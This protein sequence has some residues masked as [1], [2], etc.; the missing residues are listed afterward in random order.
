MKK[1]A[2]FVE[3]QTEQF[4]IKKLLIE[5]AG[6]KNINVQLKTF[7]GKGKSSQNVFPRTDIAE[8]VKHTALVYNCGGDESVKSRILEEYQDL[9]D[10][11]YMEVIGVRDLYPL[12]ELSKLE[13]RLLNGLILKGRVIELP[14]PVGASII[15]AVREIEDWFLIEYNHFTCIDAELTK[16][17]IE[18][19]SVE[20]G[21]NLYTNDLLIRNTSAAEDLNAIYHLVRKAY[22]KRKKNV[23]RT[24][25]CL[26]YANIYL[27]L[28]SKIEK[29]NDLITKIDNFLT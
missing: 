20:L 11:G 12:T 18:E 4:F 16:V 21:F 13:N 23:E 17:L 8:N 29:L 22:N 19:S 26:D 1:I 10:D 25:E 3:G 15:T 27:N 5:I 6:V 2:F 9:L 24:V 28:R 14:L 7:F